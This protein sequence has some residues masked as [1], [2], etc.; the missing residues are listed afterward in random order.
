MTQVR[1]SEWSGLDTG[2]A[3]DRR[4]DAP[5]DIAMELATAVT[6]SSAR[7]AGKATLE[8]IEKNDIGERRRRQVP[9]TTWSEQLSIKPAN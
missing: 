7:T 5:T 4:R 3:A 9:A 6:C 1:G 2:E 8:P